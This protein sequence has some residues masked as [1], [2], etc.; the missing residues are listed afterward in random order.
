M[1]LDKADLP[2]FVILALYY[3]PSSIETNLLRVVK[4]MKST[5]PTNSDPT[6]VPDLRAVPRLT[7][8]WDSLGACLAYLNSSAKEIAKRAESQ[9]K[10]T[11]KPTISSP[12]LSLL[13]P[14]IEL[15][16]V[17]HEPVVTEIASI[18]YSGELSSSIGE[19]TRIVPRF[20]VFVEQHRNFINELVRQYPTLLE[21][22]FGSLLSV[23]R[24]LDF[25]NKRS[26]FRAQMQV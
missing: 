5:K 15:F 22:T 8:L 19:T 17:V 21:G 10:S 11:K 16:F 23:P 25:D 7:E 14:L 20:V 3:P 1:R 24:L 12:S 2:P 6:S 9:S 18:T 4:I 26:Y 13:L